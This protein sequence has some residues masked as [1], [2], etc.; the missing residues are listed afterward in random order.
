MMPQRRART[1]RRGTAVV[2]AAVVFP[3]TLLL[4]IGTLILGLGVYQYQQLQSLAREGARY[5]AVHGPTYASEQ[6]S[7]YATSTTVLA[8]I[9]SLASAGGIQTSDLTCAVTWSPNP[10]TSSP[11]STVTVQLTYVWVPEGYFGSSTWTVSSTM[12][13]TY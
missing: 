6:N 5:A 12:P 3:T 2:E 1:S 8:A 9:D 13:V 4:L 11:P 7:S 10:P